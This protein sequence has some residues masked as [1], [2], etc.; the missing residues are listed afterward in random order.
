MRRSIRMGRVLGALAAVALAASPV[1]GTEKSDAHF[2]VG[3]FYVE[4]ARLQ[5]RP[6]PDAATAG[7]SLRNAGMR[8]PDFRL[9]D[10][11][12]E[13][14]VAAIAEVAGIHVVSSHPDAPFDQG[15]VDT[16]IQCFGLD[17]TKR[18]PPGGDGSVTPS[19]T[20]HP[21]PQPGKGK[22]KGHTQSPTDPV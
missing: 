11:L 8:L 17:L 21:D 16:F 2:T 12:T 18:K 9:T 22:S 20:T 13:G 5:S 6:A 19:G 4:L 15:Q 3:Q 14:R 10:P 7:T 1:P